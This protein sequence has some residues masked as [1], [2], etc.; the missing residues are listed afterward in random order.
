MFQCSKLLFLR[1]GQLVAG[2][3]RWLDTHWRAAKVIC[4][5]FGGYPRDWEAGQLAPASAVGCARVLRVTCGN[6]QALEE[7][8]VPVRKVYA[9][10]S[11]P[12]GLRE[13]VV[14]FLPLCQNL[15]ALHLRRIEI[16]QVPALPLLVHL[17][18]EHCFFGP[19]L[20]SL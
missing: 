18:L 15:T 8:R 4:L 5:H 7:M 13:W 10:R 2:V 17:I 9:G 6:P 19:A 14:G 20:A 1:C 3:M 12:L 16:A 11:Q